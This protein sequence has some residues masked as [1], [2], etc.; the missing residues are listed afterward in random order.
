MYENIELSF[1]EIGELAR[2]GFLNED[3][4]IYED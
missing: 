4:E 2:E 3:F 1:E